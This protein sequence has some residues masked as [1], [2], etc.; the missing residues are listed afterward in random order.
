MITFDCLRPDRINGSGYKGL[1]TPSFDRI[2]DEGVFFTN[3][4]CQ[5]PNT[6]ISHAS[7]FTGC[8]P[9][10]HGV[11]T[12]IRKISENV[13]TMAEVF[14]EAGYTTLGLPAMSLLSREAGFARGFDE[15]CLDRLKS[16][17]GILS[18]RY[19]RTASDTLELI[20]IW[21]NRSR[22][23]FF[24]WVHYFGI[25]K[26]EKSLLD[27][28]QKYR[29]EYSEYAQF[30][31]GKVVFADEQF[32]APLTAE[33]EDLGL[34]DK[35]ILILWSDH[36]ENLNMVE[37]N[38]PQWGHNWA[39]TEDVM[40]T[41]LIIRAPWVLPAGERRHH[42]A[43]SIDLFPTLLDLAGQPASMVQFEGRS[44]A[45][46]PQA[47]TACYM[48]NLCQGF[49]GLRRDRF[50]LVFYEY[51]DS[52]RKKSRFFT[53]KMPQKF[54]RVLKNMLKIKSTE[55]EGK[56]IRQTL[57]PWWKVKGEPEVILKKL[58]D[59]GNYCLY[60]LSTDPMEEHNIADE[61]PR[62]TSDLKMI[63][64]KMANQNVSIQLADLSEEEEAIIEERLKNLGYI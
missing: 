30:Y 12:P 17:E 39:L 52:D 6:W 15:Y 31:D 63:L 7:L 32:L 25:H 21:L 51:L 16:T 4:Y 27:L 47:E 40:K 48:E 41:L 58:L 1:C 19:Y 56:K 61:N 20:K 42:I 9:Y 18:H 13:K 45:A 10:R 24:A 46:S 60:D 50:K 44:L 23:P 54:Q 53:I 2:V 22:Q 28:P 55:Q 3:A 43:Q 38:L 5:A 59:N 64:S 35:T 34:L 29:R 36:G 33:L 37:H 11:R 62:L 8:N 49:V 14:R 26:V 57:A